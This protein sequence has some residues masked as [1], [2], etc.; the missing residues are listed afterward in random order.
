MHQAAS[1]QLALAPSYSFYKLKD[2]TT[3][4]SLHLRQDIGTET[5]LW[6]LSPKKSPMYSLNV[7]KRSPITKHRHFRGQQQLLQSQQQSQ[8][9]ICSSPHAQFGSGALI[10]KKPLPKQVVLW[11]SET[12]TSEAAW[13]LT[14]WIPVCTLQ[15]LWIFSKQTAN[16]FS[17][18]IWAQ[19]K[20]KTK[21]KPAVALC[22]SRRGECTTMTRLSKEQ[23]CWSGFILATC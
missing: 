15:V 11:D 19:H 1:L 13:K 8:G 7:Y 23:T 3:K 6:G 22:G 14:L 12:R 4:R 16:L 10:A 5:A 2:R 20:F 21:V 17:K 18:L 9:V